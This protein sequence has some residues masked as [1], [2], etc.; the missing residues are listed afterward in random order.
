MIYMVGLNPIN[1]SCGQTQ[2]MAHNIL[3]SNSTPQILII[4]TCSGGTFLYCR[5]VR[6][7]FGAE[8]WRQNTQY[9]VERHIVS[10]G[11]IYLVFACKD[12]YFRAIQGRLLYRAIQRRYFFG[13][14]GEGVCLPECPLVPR[15][16]SQITS[17]TSRALILVVMMMEQFSSLLLI[18]TIWQNPSVVRKQ[19]N[20]IFK[21]FS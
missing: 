5:H 13:V 17:T 12:D 16:R 3:S 21:D 1:M 2:N 7:F 9:L 20:H 19:K 10:F 8:R 14:Q 18:R 6:N 15:P 11:G 4:S